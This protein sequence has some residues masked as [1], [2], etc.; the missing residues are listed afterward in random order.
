MPK[1]KRQQLCVY[2]GIREATESEHVIPRALF[3]KPKPVIM[4]T[5]PAC[6]KCND[7]KKE[8]DEYLRDFMVID[9]E[10]TGHPSTEGPLKGKLIRAAS[11]NQSRLAKDVKEKSVLAANYTA[12]GLYLGHQTA[13]PL[14]HVRVNR[15]FEW[16][17]RG[18]YFKLHRKRLPDDTTFDIKK[19]DPIY[20][21]QVV[22][23]MVKNLKVNTSRSIGSDFECMYTLGLEDPTVTYWILRFFNV[24]LNLQR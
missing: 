15:T 16:I 18:L 14:D 2:C 24:H 1:T 17:V 5:V 22:E 7:S 6:G 3:T 13:V 10:N 23:S 11:R 20:K 12:N 21:Q 8:D 19:I 9:I 4:V